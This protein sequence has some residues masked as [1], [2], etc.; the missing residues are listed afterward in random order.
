MTTRPVELAPEPVV[1]RRHLGLVVRR[2]P[3]RG[4]A[5]REGRRCSS[6]GP[7]RL[8]RAPGG[9]PRHGRAAAGR[10]RTST[11]P[12]W[13]APDHPAAGPARSPTFEAM[14][15]DD[16]TGVFDSMRTHRAAGRPRLGVPHRR[17]ATTGTPSSPR[18]PSCSPRSSPR[19]SVEAGRYDL[20]I[21]PSQPLADHPRVDRPRHRA[22]PGARLRGQLRRHVVRDL[23]QARHA[24]VRLRRHARHRRPHRRAR[25]GHRSGTTTRASQTQSWDIVRDGVLVGYQLDRPM[26][27]HASRAQRRPL[28]RLRLRRLPRP[29]PDPADGQ[30]L[31]A[32]RRRTARPPR[33]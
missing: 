1:R 14:G 32:A 3:V 20:V 16:A 30:R 18:C 5:R 27:A 10:R 24:A 4:A 2:R 29:H 25:P 26:G 23:R 19:P 13:P 21:H 8:R 6:T 17:R 15:A 33:T 11:T 9:R 28:Q 7:T 31:A 12:T 22:R